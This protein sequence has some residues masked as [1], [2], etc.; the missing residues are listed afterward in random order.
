MTIRQRIFEMPHVA[1]NFDVFDLKVRNRRFKMRVPIDQTFA[2][3]DQ[4]FVVHLNE[5]FDD[6]V[7]EIAI[8]IRGGIWGA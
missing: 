3:I 4:T 1:C 2:A 6:G 7:M 8:L 5:N